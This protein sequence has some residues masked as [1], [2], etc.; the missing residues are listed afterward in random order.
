MAHGV[1]LTNKTRLNLQIG[2]STTFKTRKLISVIDLWY[3]YP[4]YLLVIQKK[5]LDSFYSSLGRSGYRTETVI[6]R[7]GL[8]KLSTHFNMLHKYLP[9]FTSQE[10]DRQKKIFFF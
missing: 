8:R 2:I 6:H 9:N 10:V 1:T 4:Q 7:P 3:K 5:I